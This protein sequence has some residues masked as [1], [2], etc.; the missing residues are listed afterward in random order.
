MTATMTRSTFIKPFS[1]ARAL[2]GSVALATSLVGHAGGP[3]TG[4]ASEWT[5]IMNNIELAVA[6]G[7]Q[8]KIAYNTV[9]AYE[10]Q[11]QQYYAE[12]KQLE[13]LTKV[14]RNLDEVI[15]RYNSVV[16]FRGRLEQ[17]QG[18]V[19]K[20]VEV[21]KKR[22]T[23]AQLAGQ[24][25]AEY[26]KGEKERVEQKNE[27]AIQRLQYEQG[28]FK[29]VEEDYKFARDIEPKIDEAN[30][31]TGALQV[32]NKQMNRL[33]TQNAKLTEAM[34]VKN[35][36]DPLKMQQENE[37]EAAEML[38]REYTRTVQVLKRARQLEFGKTIG[39]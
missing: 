18:S 11:L 21:M 37:R 34:A 2:I 5:Q 23:E 10:T 7:E 33:V 31:V 8:A 36:E 15:D 6:S 35:T 1:F 13:K 38:F 3:A 30:G 17:V 24:S 12:L 39:K 20:Q 26:V 25:W 28:V 19:G 4:G 22:L 14:P 29:A 9:R 16:A 32:L 27:R